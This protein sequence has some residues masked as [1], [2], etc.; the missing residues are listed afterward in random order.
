M[1]CL[2]VQKSRWAGAKCTR[3]KTE[4]N[5]LSWSQ[6]KIDGTF[7][8]FSFLCIILGH[9]KVTPLKYKSL[10]SVKVDTKNSKETHKGRPVRSE[11]EYSPN[12][13]IYNSNNNHNNDNNPHNLQ[14]KPFS[15][16][17]A[18]F[19]QMH[20]AGTMTAALQIK[21]WRFRNTSLVHVIVIKW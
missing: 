11:V 10:S 12:I 17:K 15:R 14:L 9:K 21:T 2:A 16:I 5:L 3:K 20:Q 6:N 8:V 4:R 7:I 18:H 13:L 1:P 19:I